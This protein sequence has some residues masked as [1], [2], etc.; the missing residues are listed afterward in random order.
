MSK[1]HL[2]LLKMQSTLGVYR[3]MCFR[4]GLTTL[5]YLLSMAELEIS[6]EINK[7]A[8]SGKQEINVLNGH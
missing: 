4:Q 8:V 6:D 5:A 2:D 1:K 3:D 7:T